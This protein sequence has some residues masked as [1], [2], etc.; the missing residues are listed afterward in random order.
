MSAPITITGR[1]AGDPELRFS[2]SGIAMCIFTVVTSSRRKQD[3]GTFA[4]VDTTFWDCVCWRVLAEN[5]AECVKGDRVIV[6]GKAVQDEWTDKETGQKRRKVKVK[7]DDV[8]VSL[9]FSPAKSQ[10]MQRGGTVLDADP[11]AA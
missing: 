7:A 2:A 8:G 5:L 4:D 6:A 10:R 11:W 9:L 3:D 1:L